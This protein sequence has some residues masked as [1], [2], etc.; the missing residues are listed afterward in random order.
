MLKTKFKRR[1]AD[2]VGRK[3]KTLPNQTM[4]V[5]TIIE[6]YTRGIPI[7]VKQRE[8]VYLDQDVD[9]YE[10]LS[11][12]DFDE[13]VE[14]AAALH[15]RAVSIEQRLF[16]E[17]KARKERATKKRETKIET[18]VRKRLGNKQ[19]SKSLDNTMLDDTKLATK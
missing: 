9:D 18:E 3:S 19:H 1:T 8:R 12:L 13:K 15:D 10:K 4:S 7:S 5:E 11:R 2:K 14:Y 6:K 16:D 17:D